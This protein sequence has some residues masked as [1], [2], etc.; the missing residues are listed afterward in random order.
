MT[1]QMSPASRF[2]EVEPGVRVYVEDTGVGTPVFFVHGWPVSQKMFE[3]QF[4]QFHRNGYRCIG[5]D[6]R[7][8]GRSDKPYGEYSYD[9]FADDVHK[10][11]EELN[12]RDI[13]LAGFSMGG[14]IAL[15]YVAR[16]HGDRVARL[17]LLAAAAP[18]FTRRKG[19]PYGLERS[20]VDGLI[21]ACEA[22]RPEMLAEFGKIFFYRADSVRHRFADW[23]FGLGLEASHQAT[24]SCLEVLRDGDLRSDMAKVKVPTLILH[25]VEDRVC[26]FPLAEQMHAGIGGSQLVRFEKSGHGLFFDE[27]PKFNEELTRFIGQPAIQMPKAA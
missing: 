13:T 10:V 15:H 25:G 22:N 4:S 20:V 26:L 11:L 17:A 19:F 23:F 9:V 12:L 8:F 14:A 16:H 18:S 24:V 6:L 27:R 1:M 2:I 3:Y 5:I 21:D 7:G